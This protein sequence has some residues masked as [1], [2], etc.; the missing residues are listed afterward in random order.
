MNTMLNSVLGDDIHKFLHK[1]GGISNNP[2]LKIALKASTFDNVG[3][4]SDDELHMYMSTAQKQDVLQILHLLPYAS[5]DF[6]SSQLWD[7][8][9]EQALAFEAVCYRNKYLIAVLQTRGRKSFL[10]LAILL[11]EKGITVVIFSY[12]ALTQDMH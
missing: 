11:I 4:L 6:P 7:R 5:F 12:I 10:F 8:S 2:F 9:V 1:L 3:L